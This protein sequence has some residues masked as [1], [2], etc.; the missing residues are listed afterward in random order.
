[1]TGFFITL[2]PRHD[3]DRAYHY[4]GRILFSAAFYRIPESIFQ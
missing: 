2:L 4:F 3:A 1:M